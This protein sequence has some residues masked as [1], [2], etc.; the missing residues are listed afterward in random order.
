MNTLLSILDI[1]VLLLLVL[2]VLRV[3]WKELQPGSGST[4]LSVCVALA[5][6][7]FLIVSLSAYMGLVEVSS[8]LTRVI[9]LLVL[10]V[11]AGLLRFAWTG[12]TAS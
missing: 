7:V 9:F 10:V 3:V 6:A 12:K 4:L 11:M 1:L 2:S 8:A 5:L